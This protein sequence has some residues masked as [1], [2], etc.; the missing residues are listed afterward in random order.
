[1]AL[2]NMFREFVVDVA[3]AG[4]SIN[5]ADTYRIREFK[6]T[7]EYEDRLLAVVA[8]IRRLLLKDQTDTQQQHFI[9]AAKEI[10]Q[11]AENQ[12][13]ATKDK[14]AQKNQLSKQ[15]RHDGFHSRLGAIRQNRPV[16]KLF[17]GQP[18][19]QPQEEEPIPDQ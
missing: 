10:Y 6:K 7:S 4:A 12:A 17:F 5:P 3:I 11:N 9:A 14:R 18:I 16:H 2:S 19:P 15:K 8:D 13:L 1:M